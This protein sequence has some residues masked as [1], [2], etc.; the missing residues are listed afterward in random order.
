MLRKITLAIYQ[1]G[2]ILLYPQLSVES[3]Q[4]ATYQL[5]PKPEYQLIAIL[6]YFYGRDLIFSQESQLECGQFA[7]DEICLLGIEY[8]RWIPCIVIQVKIFLNL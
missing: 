4:K 7:K 3:P 5:H 8:L 6:L 1:M 2:N